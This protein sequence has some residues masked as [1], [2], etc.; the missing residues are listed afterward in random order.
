[1]EKRRTEIADALPTVGA[2]ND[3]TETESSNDET[4][5]HGNRQQ[6]YCLI[7]RVCRNRWCHRS[8]R[9][10]RRGRAPGQSTRNQNALSVATSNH[11][12]FDCAASG[13]R[14]ASD[15]VDRTGL[16]GHADQ[17][18][19]RQF[20]WRH[21]WQR[22]ERWQP[23]RR[24][25]E[26]DDTPRWNHAEYLRR[27]PTASHAICGHHTSDCCNSSYLTSCDV[28]ASTPAASH[29][30]ERRK[31]P[32]SEHL[33]WY[34]ARSSGVVA[35]GVLTASV[36]FGLMLSTR[37]FGR[38]VAPAWLMEIHR[39][40]G[41]LGIAATLL[42]VAALI[43]DSYTNFGLKDVLVPFASSWKP[44]PVAWGVLA[45][46]LLVIIE[47][48]SLVMHKMPRS[49]WHAMHMTSMVLFCVSLVHGLQA[50]T[51]AGQRVSETIAIS[52]A[53]PVMFLV[54]VRYLAPRRA[55]QRARRAPP[56]SVAGA[57]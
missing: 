29:H 51:D 12:L 18:A 4:T 37:L 36:A 44:G 20:Y 15:L 11:N 48:T 40:L 42:H 50:G 45:L 22:E 3:A 21:T 49:V 10:A 53:M 47:A 23:E 26:R 1:M 33:W 31:Q 41:A 8:G 24:R 43:A 39:Y 28:D 57:S 52:T 13:V 55:A 7:N 17:T 19:G 54:I 56:S 32:M 6:N 30:L 25:I 46:W 34:I 27:G 9:G 35:F 14:I 38:S 5:T 2:C 16:A